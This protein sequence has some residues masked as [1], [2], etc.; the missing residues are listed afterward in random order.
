MGNRPPTNE[1]GIY[2][3]SL[4]CVYGC[5]LRGLVVRVVTARRLLVGGKREAS[6][7]STVRSDHSGPYPYVFAAGL[8]SIMGLSPLSNF[9]L[10]L[11]LTLIAEGIDWLAI[12]FWT[13]KGA[14]VVTWGLTAIVVFGW[15]PLIHAQF[16]AKEEWPMPRWPRF[17]TGR[18]RKAT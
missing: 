12:H 7:T 11:L 4:Y 15:I 1:H 14:A 6:A 10:P 13:G 8:C 16:L 17:C 18:C 2:S 3:A 5:W 9:S